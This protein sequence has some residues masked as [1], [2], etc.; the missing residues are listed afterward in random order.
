VDADAIFLGTQVR[1]VEGQ[2]FLGH[3]TEYLLEHARQAVLVLVF[4]AADDPA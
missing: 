2:P 4:P 3:G 1:S